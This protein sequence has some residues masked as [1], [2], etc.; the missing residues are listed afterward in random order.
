[1][2]LMPVSAASALLAIGVIVVNPVAAFAGH[3]NPATGTSTTS[4][5]QGHAL[6]QAPTPTATPTSATKPAAPTPTVTPTAALTAAPTT[7]PTAD[8]TVSAT[9][10]PTPP[11]TANPTPSA[12]STPTPSATATPTPAPSTAPTPRPR[13]D[14]TIRVRLATQQQDSNRSGG[15][16]TGDAVISVF[17]VTNTGDVRVTGLALVDRSG[18]HGTCGRTTLAPHSATSCR[19]VREVA[20]ADMDRG[21]LTVGG[22]ATARTDDGR[23]PSSTS[24]TM[25][26]RLRQR[27]SLAASQVAVAI[28]PRPGGTV[29]AGDRLTYR[30]RVV[31]TG[32][33]TI[34]RLTVA[35]RVI[36][37]SGAQVT[38][39]QTRLSPGTSTTCRSSSYTVTRTQ[40]QR[41]VL[42]NFMTASARTPGGSV[43]TSTATVTRLGVRHEAA[44]RAPATSGAK[45][46]PSHAPA[47]RPKPHPRL[48]LQHW[49]SGVN[50][51]NKNGALDPAD[52]IAYSFRVANTGSVQLDHVA[53][54]D[55]RLA[56]AKLAIH[57]PTSRVAPGHSFVCHTDAW[58]VTP[59]QA[60]HG[61]GRN[62]A[63]ATAVTANA[64]PVRSAMS[65]SV[66]GRSAVAE[67]TAP[68]AELAMTGTATAPLL[69][70][71]GMLLALGGSL[72]ALSRRRQRAGA[73][74]GS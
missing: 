5:P 56:A 63:F 29:A 17:T 57:C 13:Q 48:A 1:M 54:H 74:A 61:I 34:T 73:P 65:V 67:V 45:P 11:A 7:S 69:L 8:P 31:N 71:A 42:E 18:R 39:P 55:A 53:V 27:A 19:T 10:T 58:V 62:Y 59:F 38:C 14:A 43:V 22:R 33:V 44:R 32:T 21:S 50:D 12:T 41:G 23:T 51:R 66:H 15:R 47:V 40:A 30:L 37:R 49:I 26:V 70:G 52:T 25:T 6:V 72:C 46:A 2:K 9:S 35:D 64:K 4:S 16:D 20:Q 68:A 60:K 3:A 24:S 28:S 36:A